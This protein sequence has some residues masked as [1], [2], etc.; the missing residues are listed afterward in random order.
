[1]TLMQHY[2]CVNCMAVLCHGGSD[3]LYCRSCGRSFPIIRDIPILTSRPRELLMVHVQELRQALTAFESKRALLPAADNGHSPGM[4]ERTRQ[5]LE[6]MSSNLSLIARYTKPIGDYLARN[7][8][9]PANLIDWALAQNAGS[10][11]QV[12]LPFF[13]QD[14]GR[15]REYEDVESRIIQALTD[16]SPDREAVAVLGAGACGLVHAGAQHF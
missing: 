13:Y 12:M 9:K 8:D 2:S 5:M 3:D 16:H 11:P 15:T 7:Q 6:G 4:M 1:M 14:W 10:V